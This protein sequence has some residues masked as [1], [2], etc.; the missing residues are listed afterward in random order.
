MGWVK[1][2]RFLKAS[3]HQ[4]HVQSDEMRTAKKLANASPG[5][6]ESLSVSEVG[7]IGRQGLSAMSPT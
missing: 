1:S 6:H 3:I 5:R 2:R 4:D 7:P